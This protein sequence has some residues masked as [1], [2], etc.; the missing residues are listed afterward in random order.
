MWVV[1]I[2]TVLTFEFI[3]GWVAITAGEM[4][5]PRRTVKRSVNP[6]FWRMFLFYWVNMWL[7]GMCV[8]YNSPDLANKGTLASPFIIA[9]REGGSPAFANLINAMVFIT[10]L[11][12]AIT[13]FYVASRSLTHMSDLGIIH[14]IF[15]RKDAAG[16]PWVSLI[17]SGLLGGGLTYLN[18]DSTSKQVYTW[19]SSLVSQSNW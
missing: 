4:K 5:D 7:V 1:K 10:V 17:L 12:A 19:F 3:A 8:P 18:L 16:R 2:D 15:K 11:S 14:P 9:I 6:I 13:S